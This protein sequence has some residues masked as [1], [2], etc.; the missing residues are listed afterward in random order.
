MEYCNGVNKS[1]HF[2]AICACDVT[3]QSAK[4]ISRW[5]TFEVEMRVYFVIYYSFVEDWKVVRDFACLEHLIATALCFLLVVIT[6]IAK[7]FVL[8]NSELRTPFVS[9]K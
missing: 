4:R 9:T 6:T 5:Y 8:R 1:L 7:R 3:L 2:K